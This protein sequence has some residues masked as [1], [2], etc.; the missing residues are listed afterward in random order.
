MQMW[1]NR[2]ETSE[3]RATCPKSW[4]KG[5]M[6][7]SLKGGGGVRSTRRKRLGAFYGRLSALQEWLTVR[8][9]PLARGGVLIPNPVSRCR[10]GRTGARNSWNQPGGSEAGSYSRLADF[11]HYSTQGLGVIT[12]ERVLETVQ[13]VEPKPR[14][15]MQMWQD[16]DETHNFPQKYQTLNP[17]PHTPNPTP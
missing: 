10:C 14:F 6:V 4:R 15:E 17:K 16:R 8:T 11:V 7:R 3:R 9:C 2:D 5:G 12:R 13:D 1:Q